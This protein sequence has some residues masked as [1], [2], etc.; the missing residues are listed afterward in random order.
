MSTGLGVNGYRPQSPNGLRPQSPSGVL[1]ESAS[2]SSL[3]GMGTRF[4]QAGGTSP[5]AGQQHGLGTSSSSGSLRQGNWTMVS[6]NSAGN[7]ANA[8]FGNTLQGSVSTG[9]L[10]PTGAMGGSISKSSLLTTGSIGSD[11]GPGYVKAPPRSAH[12]MPSLS[13]GTRMPSSSPTPAMVQPQQQQPPMVQQHHMLQQQPMVQQHPVVPQ[14]AMVQQQAVVPQ[15]AMVQQQQSVVPQQPPVRQAIPAQPLPHQPPQ[16][17]QAPAA[18]QAAHLQPQYAGAPAH[19]AGFGMGQAPLAQN[20]AMQQMH[21][22]TPPRQGVLPSRGG[23]PQYMAQGAPPPTWV[24]EE[25]IDFGTPYEEVNDDFNLR[26]C[27]HAGSD[28]EGHGRPGGFWESC[29]RPF[30]GEELA[31]Q[32][33]AS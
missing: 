12:V 7:L 29:L 21:H 24:I 23:P 13:E 5:A 31:S 2:S 32:D 20:G 3:G 10:K 30:L 6:S 4:R 19:A 27:R 18:M 16:A 15:Q 1:G 8:R 14:Q 33:C 17:Q 28:S 26:M 22:P 9:S 25:V 11:A